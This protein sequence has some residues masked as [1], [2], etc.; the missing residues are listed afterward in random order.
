MNG[1]KLFGKA[2]S[3]E[4]QIILLYIGPPPYSINSTL[5]SENVPSLKSFVLIEFP[6]FE[7]NV[8]VI[9]NIF[10]DYNGIIMTIKY[11]NNE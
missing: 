8:Y 10:V 6:S 11:M 5:N 3:Y 9:K 4:N 1:T 7:F 2:E